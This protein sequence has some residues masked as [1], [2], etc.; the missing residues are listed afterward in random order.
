LRY[1]GSQLPFADKS[2]DIVWSNAVIE[3]VGGRD[4]QLGFLREIK[5]VGRQAFIT[6]PNRLFPIEI[7]TRLPFAHWLPRPWFDRIATWAGKSWAT[8]DYMHLLSRRDIR[9]LMRDANINNYN[10]I[11]NR[12]LGL[13]LDFVIL[14]K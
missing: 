9:H 2:F 6:T 10:I 1:N 8:G 3:H 4:S 5:R 11:D 13:T 12:I 14:Q 7:H